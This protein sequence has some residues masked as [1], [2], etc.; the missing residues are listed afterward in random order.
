[1]RTHTILLGTLICAVATAWAAHGQTTTTSQPSTQTRPAEPRVPSVTLQRIE[2]S[3]FRIT[4]P[5]T[6]S[7]SAPPPAV[8]IPTTAMLVR[9]SG[10]DFTPNRVGNFEFSEIKDDVATDLIADFARLP[11][12]RL[13]PVYASSSGSTFTTTFL[14]PQSPRKASRLLSLKG[15]LTVV[16]GGEPKVLIVPA[17]RK[18]LD[19]SIDAPDFKNM[20]LSLKVLPPSLTQ[21]KDQA[22]NV[23]LTGPSEA[24]TEMKFIDKDGRDITS[25]SSREVR[26]EDHAE[27]YFLWAQ[28]LDAS[29]S[30]KIEYMTGQKKLTIPINL[31]DITLP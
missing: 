19:K 25:S 3:R 11:K 15:E 18:L 2:D 13:Q 10:V 28:K 30:L 29:T 31:K 1:M 9:I 23:V 14:I 21:Y 24:V 20:G 8:V 27:E 16:G 22:I 6:V 4:E 5:H 17:I 7:P 12:Q 26:D